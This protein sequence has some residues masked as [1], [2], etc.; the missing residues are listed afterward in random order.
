MRV[1][2]GRK[3]RIL[4][5]SHEDALYKTHWAHLKHAFDCLAK[6]CPAQPNIVHSAK[7]ELFQ[8]DKTSF[9]LKELI[10]GNST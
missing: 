6:C 2:E 7:F 10:A 5:L 1:K 9:M 3:V 4:I 8:R